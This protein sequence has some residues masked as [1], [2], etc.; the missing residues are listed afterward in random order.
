M[1]HPPRTG[2]RPPERLPLLSSPANLSAS[3]SPS[4]DVQSIRA[5]HWDV[6]IRVCKKTEPAAPLLSIPRGCPFSTAPPTRCPV[7]SKARCCSRSLNVVV[8]QPQ[9]PIVRAQPAD[10]LLD[11]CCPHSLC[12][13]R[14]L[15]IV[16][17]IFSPA[18]TNAYY[19]QTDC[20]QR[21]IVVLFWPSR[22]L[23]SG[24]LLAEPPVSSLHDRARD[25]DPRVLLSPPPQ[26][27]L[28][29]LETNAHGV[30]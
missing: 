26:P 21:T 15:P 2:T 3:A 23:M 18:F 25:L 4:H 1:D 7:R 5:R 17:V 28:F 27:R 20:P 14:R 9:P 12:P 16:L 6:E 29:T 19:I 13:E 24:P 11:T 22:G 30:V 8:V 10:Y